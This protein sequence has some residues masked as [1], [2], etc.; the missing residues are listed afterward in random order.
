M[1]T[2]MTKQHLS[3]CA[4]EW[5]NKVNQ[6]KC[7]LNFESSIEFGKFLRKLR[8][9]RSLREIASATGLSHTYIAD[10]E[11]G[12]RRGT[13]QPIHPSLKT[14]V[15]LAEVYGISSLELMALAGYLNKVS[16]QQIDDHP[17]EYNVDDFGSFIRSLR[18]KNGLTLV[19]VSEISGLSHA[20]ISRI[21]NGLRGV[22]SP[23]GINGLSLALSV[24]YEQLMSAAGYLEKCEMDNEHTR[25]IE[26]LLQENNDLLK[27]N[28]ALRVQI[29][30]LK[31]VISVL[32]KGE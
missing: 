24:P 3:R 29:K 22:P 6:E 10:V 28:N 5:M 4:N 13:N 26:A 27:E 32:M 17:I 25:E 16:E 8:G 11:N 15:K 18:Q 31:E 23:K 21:E 2:N 14:L 9:R 12:F 30:T 19:E 1:T 7:E 20:H